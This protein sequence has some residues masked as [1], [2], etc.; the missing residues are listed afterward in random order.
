M[1]NMKL[2][3]AIIA[4]TALCAVSC[5]DDYV[6]DYDRIACGFANQTDVRSLIV[7]EGMTFSTGVALGGTIDNEKD[8]YVDVA[9]DYSLVNEQTYSLLKGHTFSYIAKLMQNVPSISALPASIYELETGTGVAGR[10]CIAKGSHLGKI[11]IQVDS[12]AFLADAGRL[13]P[14]DVIPLKIISAEGIDIMEGRES[15]VIGVRYENTLFGNWYHGG[16]AVVKN[17]GGDV[18]RE[19]DYPMSIPQADNLVWTLTTVSPFELTANAVAASYNGNAAQMKLRL[20]EDGSI[21]VSSVP[22]AQFSVEPDGESRFIRSKL[23]QDRK[24]VLKYKYE[25]N[26][27]TV[28]ASD[29]LKFRNRIRDGVNEWQ[30]ENS[31]HYEK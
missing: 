25:D 10:V 13:Y 20:E 30:D 3:Y 6:G 15:S 21:T 16:H 9:L 5:Y 22:G 26:G 2:K 12:A 19:M 27:E 23:L 28:H 8:R 11:S 24:I 29:T 17:A 18:L 1:K 14:K 7:G 4:L 31:S